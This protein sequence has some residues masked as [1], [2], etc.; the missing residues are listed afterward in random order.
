MPY[1]QHVNSASNLMKHPGLLSSRSLSK[2]YGNLSGINT[3]LE[4]HADLKNQSKFAAQL[5]S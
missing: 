3:S 5:N 1:Q 4:S 2:K